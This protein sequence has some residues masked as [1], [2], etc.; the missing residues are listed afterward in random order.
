MT[1]SPI[2]SF[3]EDI[4]ILSYSEESVVGI[5]IP[6]SLLPSAFPKEDFP[7]ALTNPKNLLND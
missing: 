5:L 4:T 3:A 2:Q 6:L 1:R 7:L